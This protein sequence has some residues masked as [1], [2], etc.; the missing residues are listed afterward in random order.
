MNCCS[1]CKNEGF[2]SRLVAIYINKNIPDGVVCVKCG[3]RFVGNIPVT[4]EDIFK[5]RKETGES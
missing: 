4:A 5:W 2:E 3:Q 1:I